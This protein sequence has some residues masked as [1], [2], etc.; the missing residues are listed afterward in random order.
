[1]RALT[2]NLYHGREYPPVRDLRGR[3]ARRPSLRSSFAAVLAREEWSVA[4]L[5]EAPPRWLTALCRA[6]GAHGALARTARNLGAPLKRPLADWNAH[7][8][9]SHE[10][11]SNAVLVRPPWRIESTRRLTL[12]RR[13]ERRRMLWARLRGPG[14]EALCVASLHL[15]VR[16]AAAAGREALSAAEHATRWSGADPLLLG[17]DFNL[18]AGPAFVELESRFGLAAPTA[19]RRSIDHLL[20]HGLAVEEAP[21]P[22]PTE[23]RTVPGSGGAPVTLSDHPLVAARFASEQA[24]AASRTP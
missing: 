18:S 4:L 13:P 16:D 3:L 15:T 24:Q 8:L 5:Q 20:V 10:G 2:W 1:M 14:G 17:G 7:L 23:R 9:A 21:R 12:A 6:A 11:G 19:G 22:L